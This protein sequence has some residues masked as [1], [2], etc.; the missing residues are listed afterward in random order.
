[1]E[2]RYCAGKTCRERG[3]I[4]IS[5]RT[6]G[7]SGTAKLSREKDGRCAGL[8]FV[9]DR[10]IGAGGSPPSKGSTGEWRQAFLIPTKTTSA[11]G[12]DKQ[13]TRW[14]RAKKKERRPMTVHAA[15]DH[16]LERPTD[17]TGYEKC[18]P[19]RRATRL[20]RPVLRGVRSEICDLT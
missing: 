6:Y 20:T 13:L 7:D 12:S 4:L 11:W 17:E 19:K 16:T 1:M 18:W 10:Q 5:R 8:F 14:L 3:G 9:E 2:V 15:V